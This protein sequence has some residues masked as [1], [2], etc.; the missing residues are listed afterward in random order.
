MARLPEAL[1]PLQLREDAVT[2]QQ[3][4][5]QRKRAVRA[6]QR[7]VDRLVRTVE[8]TGPLLEEERIR[9]FEREHGFRPAPLYGPHRV[10]DQAA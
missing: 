9:A 6:F 2:E 10:A 8:K 4:Q 1:A 5:K 3:Q 7:R